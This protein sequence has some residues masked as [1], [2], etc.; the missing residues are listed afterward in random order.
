MVL[1]KPAPKGLDMMKVPQTTG[2]PGWIILTYENSIP[3]CLWMTEKECQKLPCI[4]DERICG[5]TFFR[6]EK[7]APLEFVVCDIWMYNSN[8]VFACS[9]FEKRYEWTRELL[10]TFTFHVHGTV[11]LIH[12]SNYDFKTIK[13]YEHHTTET[14]GKLGYSTSNNTV[15][16]KAL[17]LPDCYEITGKSGYLKVPDL[18]T[19][20]YLRSLGKTFEC[21]CIQNED[22]SWS[23]LENIPE[24][25]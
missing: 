21:E 23:L 16:I 4:A 15:K 8:C 17:E 18:K 7:V 13:G 14:I 2:T 6:V 11:K 22:T 10:S 12:K 5:D 19:S 3:V 20:K 9:T 25:D 1:K 24:I